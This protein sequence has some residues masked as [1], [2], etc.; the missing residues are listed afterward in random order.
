M[1]KKITLSMLRGACAEQRAIFKKEWPKG[2]E[3]TLENVQRAIELCLDLHWGASQ[4]FTP[5]AWAEYLSQRAAFLAE[6]ERQ[7][8]PL[9]A[10]YQRQRAAL[11]AEYERREAPLWA[12]FLA[13]YERQRAPLLAE[14]QRQRAALWLRCALMGEPE[15]G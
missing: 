11:L 3:L 9:L 6:Y 2:A 1:T 7:E 15:Q 14:F 8:A 10:E 13:E 4:W 12:E 5:A